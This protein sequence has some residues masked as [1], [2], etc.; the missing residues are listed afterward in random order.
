MP[1]ETRALNP[2]GKLADTRKDRQL[3]H[4]FRAL[5]FSA[6]GLTRQH[7]MNILKQ[8]LGFLFAFPFNSPVIMDAD[9]F[10]IAQPDP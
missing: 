3:P 2:R 6:V 5:L 1:S 9:A 10:E 4:F 8:L 7:V